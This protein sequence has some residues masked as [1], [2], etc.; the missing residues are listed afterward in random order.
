[1]AGPGLARQGKARQGEDLRKERRGLAGRGQAR[2]GL[3]GPGEARQGFST[4]RDA[5]RRGVAGLGGARQGKARSLNLRKEIEVRMKTLHMELRGLS[6]LLMHNPAGMLSLQGG[7]QTLGRKN[8]P[9][10]EDEAKAS[11]YVL[12]DGNLYVPA[13]AVRNSLL[14]GA[15]GQLVN[16]KAAMPFISGGILMI[17]EAFPLTRNGKPIK[18]TDYSLDV[19]RAVVQRQ[20]ITRV[21]ARIELPWQVNCAFEYNPEIVDI[22]LVEAVAKLA[23]QRVGLL[24]YRVEKK[25]WFGR[26][27]VAKVWAE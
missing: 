25:G 18:G 5:A 1:M 10:P 9:K 8:I 24:D 12:P 3:V 6:P 22:K 15:K 26:F 21:R 13:I 4:R 23:G 7:E 19:R 14:N 20:G 17:D 27:E 2:R 11:R 16:R